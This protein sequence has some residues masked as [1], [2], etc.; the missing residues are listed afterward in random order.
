MKRCDSKTCYI[1][2]VLIEGALGHSLSAQSFEKEEH[3]CEASHDNDDQLDFTA[4]GIDA[5]LQLT[6]RNER[7]QI[8]AESSQDAIPYAGADGRINQKFPKVHPRQSCGHRNQLPDARNE[9]AGDGGHKAMVVEVALALLY[10]LLVEQAKVA[11]AA[12][13]EPIDDRT[14]EKISGSIVDGCSRNG[15]ERGKQHNEENVQAACGGIVGS[16]RHDNL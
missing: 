4:V 13:G 9:S 11:Q 12:V 6:C 2:S 5:L 14:P 7:M 15:P 8:P 3:D 1:P 16:R 10:L